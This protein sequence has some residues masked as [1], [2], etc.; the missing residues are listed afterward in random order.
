MVHLLFLLDCIISS[1]G[2]ASNQIIAADPEISGERDPPCSA[3]LLLDIAIEAAILRACKQNL[4]R[5]CVGA[6]R[7]R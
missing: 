3:D 4:S 7:R 6:W 5:L 2:Q 1:L